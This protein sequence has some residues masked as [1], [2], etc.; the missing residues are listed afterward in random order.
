MSAEADLYKQ[1]IE[2]LM[3]TGSSELIANSLPEHAAALLAC[4]FRHAASEIKIVCTQLRD[5][6]WD[7]PELLT[8]MR[9]AAR[10]GRTIQIVVR[11]SP[12]RESQFV[13]AFQEEQRNTPGKLFIQLDGQSHSDLIP[14]LRND[15]AVMDQKAYRWETDGKDVTAVACMNDPNLATVLS[16]V[17]DRMYSSVGQSKGPALASTS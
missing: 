5:I 8:A 10:N 13:R 4:F 3:L 16:G 1:N 11:N 15:F 2:R 7:A 17:F 6:V 12:E 14:K 9:S